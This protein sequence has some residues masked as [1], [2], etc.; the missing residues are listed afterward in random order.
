MQK[1]EKKC[2]YLNI[3]DGMLQVLSGQV[4]QEKWLQIFSLMINAKAKLITY[5]HGAYFTLGEQ[6]GTFGWT[7]KGST[8]RKEMKHGRNRR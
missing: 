1:K 2:L 6:I 7:V 8:L 3:A 5:A 4:I